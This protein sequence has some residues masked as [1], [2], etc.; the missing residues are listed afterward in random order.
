MKLESK[1]WLTLGFLASFFAY[2]LFSN[3][4]WSWLWF[5]LTAFSF[6]SYTRVIYLQSHGDWS[7]MAF[8][9]WLTTIN[10][11]IDEILFDPTKIG[12][13]EYIGFV[14]IVLISIKFKA[15]WIK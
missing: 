14:T 12:L 7:L 9:V 1:I 2:S 10:S 4:Y 11:F 8:I 3:E 15:K 13:N 6:I 5:D